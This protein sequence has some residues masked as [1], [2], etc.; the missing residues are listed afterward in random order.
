MSWAYVWAVIFAGKYR[1]TLFIP[2]ILILGVMPD[3]DIFFRSFGIEHQSFTHSI[4]FWLVIFVPFLKFKSWKGIPYLV[5]VLQHFCFGDFL[6][7]T[8]MLFWPFTSSSFGYNALMTSMFDVA[9]ETG[10]FLLALGIMYFN[11]DLKR[12]L[13]LEMRNLLMSIPLLAVSA[14]MLYFAVDWPIIPLIDYVWSSP[15]LTILVLSH[16]VLV[17]FLAIS[18]AQGLRGTISKI[19]SKVFG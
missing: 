8:I 11:G 14:S 2:I 9:L 12:L 1:R 18:T 15:S 6:I 3:I 17:T 10:G 5:S 7:G 4:L 16:I 13:S 19:Y